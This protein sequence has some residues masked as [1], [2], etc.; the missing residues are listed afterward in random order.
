[1]TDLLAAPVPAD[2]PDVLS[3]STIAV[4]IPAN[5]EEQLIDRCLLSVRTARRRLA[6]VVPAVGV[7]VVVALDSCTDGT[8]DRVAGHPEVEPVTCDAGRVGG[9]RMAAADRA[10]RMAGD[11]RSLWLACTDADS[12]VHPDW[13]VEQHLAATGGVD[14]LL[15]TVRPILGGARLQQWT[16]RHTLTDGHPHVHGANLG[17]AAEMYLQ[18]GGFADLAAHEDIDLVR[19]VRA[20][21]GRVRATGAAPVLTSARETGRTPAGFAGYLAALPPVAAG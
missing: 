14:L 7:R 20:A 11:P 6:A 13:L 1:M 18:A 9:A 15:G 10:L 8:E 19:R 4:L 21:G 2:P 5:N 17:I 12:C 16:D 3:C